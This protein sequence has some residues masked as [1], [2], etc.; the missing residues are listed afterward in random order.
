MKI[1]KKNQQ[2]EKMTTI[3]NKMVPLQYYNE[4]NGDSLYHKK[5]QY[6]GI[7]YNGN[8]LMIFRLQNG[9]IIVRQLCDTLRYEL[10][11]IENE[12]KSV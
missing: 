11:N 4:Y 7:D 1:K 12:T 9:N 2:N 6:L 3:P 5:I 8:P 10:C